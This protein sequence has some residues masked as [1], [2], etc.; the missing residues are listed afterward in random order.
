MM[1]ARGRFDSLLPTRKDFG[2]NFWRIFVFGL[3]LVVVVASAAAQAGAPAAATITDPTDGIIHIGGG[4]ALLILLARE[5]LAVYKSRRNGESKPKLASLS[6]ESVEE[7]LAM[8]AEALR[9]LVR[10]DVRNELT[11]VVG[12]LH[13]LE[14]KRELHQQ[15]II[16]L[17]QEQA[18][19]INTLVTI[20]R[21]RKE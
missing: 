14:S 3:A 6:V 8:R 20:M 4:T 5:V 2:L 21:E 1:P 16:S 17:L 10:H 13:Q 15:Q 19:G 18:L 9:T 11:T 7:K 12:T